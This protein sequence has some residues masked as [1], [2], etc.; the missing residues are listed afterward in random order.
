[1]G[2]LEATMQCGQAGSEQGTILRVS[3]AV[4][5]SYLDNQTLSALG[6]R[7]K[8]AAAPRRLRRPL[9]DISMQ[10]V[11]HCIDVI[12]R[13]LDVSAGAAAQNRVHQARCIKIHG[14][15]GSRNG[16]QGTHRT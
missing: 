12:Q 4:N 16:A 6:L 7:I 1:M 3:H 10:S 11:I 15:C 9:Q 8:A 5:P 13:L 2:G 14:I